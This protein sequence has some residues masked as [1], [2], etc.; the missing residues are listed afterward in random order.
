MRLFYERELVVV[1]DGLLAFGGG[2]SG[3]KEA[4]GG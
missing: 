2:E 4:E 3:G 1:R